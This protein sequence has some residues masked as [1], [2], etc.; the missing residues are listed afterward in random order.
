MVFSPPVLSTCHFPS[1]LDEFKV[2]P[3]LVMVVEGDK[4]GITACS[5]RR[6]AVPG[7]GTERTIDRGARSKDWTT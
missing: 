3:Q 6:G 1:V 2:Y 5:G 7:G 4:K